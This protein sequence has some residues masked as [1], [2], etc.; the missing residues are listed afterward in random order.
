M[1]AQSLNKKVLRETHEACRPQHIQ[2]VHGL[3]CLGVGVP[4]PVLAGGTP[5][6][7]G[8]GRR[9]IMG[10]SIM[11]TPSWVTPFGRDLGPVQ[12]LLDGDGV[13]PGKDVGPVEVL[14]DGNKVPPRKDM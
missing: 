9:V 14:W 2:S 13:P 8:W 12:L 6:R 4:H 3:S 7:S 1:K 11:D 5:S 10:E